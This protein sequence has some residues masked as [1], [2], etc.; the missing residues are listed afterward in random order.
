MTINEPAVPGARLL[1][2]GSKLYPNNIPRMLNKDLTRFMQSLILE[3][4]EIKQAKAGR[5]VL[6]VLI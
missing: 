6:W 1:D 3:Y 5:V 4:A 2:P